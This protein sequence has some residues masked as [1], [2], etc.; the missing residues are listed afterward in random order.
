QAGDFVVVRQAIDGAAR[1]EA[2]GDIAYHAAQ[3]QETAGGTAND[4]GGNFTGNDLA[5]TA[6]NAGKTGKR[7]VS[8][9]RRAQLAEIAGRLLWVEQPVQVHAGVDILAG[10]TQLQA[11]KAVE[12]RDA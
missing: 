9:D 1:L 3:P 10:I 11:S 2:V 5:V 6:A 8:F 4:G 7:L 12:V